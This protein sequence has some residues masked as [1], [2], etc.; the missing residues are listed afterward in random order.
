M[1]QIGDEASFDLLAA[2]PTHVECVPM[3]KRELHHLLTNDTWHCR[4]TITVTVT[5]GFFVGYYTHCSPSCANVLLRMASLPGGPQD[6]WRP[7]RP[8]CY[9]NSVQHGTHHTAL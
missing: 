8:A 9:K 2:T 4:R 1:N 6:A 7:Q 5:I 3:Q